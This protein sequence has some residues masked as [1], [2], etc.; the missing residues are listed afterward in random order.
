MS[1]Q[2]FCYWLQGYLEVANPETV[3]KEQLGVIQKHLNMVF[4]HEIDPK[5]PNQEKLDEAH[6][7]PTKPP[8]SIPMPVHHNSDLK[9][10]C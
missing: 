4:L 6:N 5:Y 10:R 3:S 8:G 1:P 9:F 2:D 7:G